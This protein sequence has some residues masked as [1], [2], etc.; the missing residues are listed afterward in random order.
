MLSYCA[1]STYKITKKR[2]YDL[3][4]DVCRLYDYNT[5]LGCDAS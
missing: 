2:R 3:K 1:I 5:Y 4:Y